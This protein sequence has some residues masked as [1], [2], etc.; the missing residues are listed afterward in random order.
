MLIFELFPGKDIGIQYN[1]KQFCENTGCAWQGL[2]EF[3]KNR[4][5]A[6]TF[7]KRVWN[8]TT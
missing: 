8:C 2:S 7:T 5:D 4:P 6:I 3:D 1:I